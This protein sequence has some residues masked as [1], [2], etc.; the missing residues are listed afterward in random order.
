MTSV[1]AFILVLGL[2]GGEESRIPGCPPPSPIQYNDVRGGAQ[3]LFVSTWSPLP[4]LPCGEGF[5]GYGVCCENKALEVGG[6]GP[7]GGVS[8]KLVLILLAET[9]ASREEIPTSLL[10]HLPDVRLLVVGDGEELVG[11]IFKCFVL[12]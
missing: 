10:V 1:S 12:T 5:E 6:E 9:I 4:Q 2:G 11:H 7:A 8:A 3:T